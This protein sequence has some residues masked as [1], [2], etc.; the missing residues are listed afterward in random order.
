MEK[1]VKTKELLYKNKQNHG[2]KIQV[3]KDTTLLK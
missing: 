1:N 2:L 3:K